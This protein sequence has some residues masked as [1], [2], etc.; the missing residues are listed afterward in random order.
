LGCRLRR[1]LRPV[2]DEEGDWEEDWDE[3][4]DGVCVFDEILLGVGLRVGVWA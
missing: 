3:E 2:A 4:W 1:G